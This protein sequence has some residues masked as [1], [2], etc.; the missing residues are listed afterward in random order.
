MSD[1]EETIAELNKHF[2]RNTIISG[3]DMKAMDIARV[4]TGS[5]SLDIETGGG[6]PYGRV[7]ELFGRE[8]TGKSFMA[9]KTA[10]QV[11]KAGKKVVWIDVEGSF[12]ATWAERIGLNVSQIHLARP[13]KGEVACDILDAVIRSGDCGLAVLDSTAALIPEADLDKSM[14][15]VEQI[16][17]RAK[18]VNRLTRKL[19]AALNQRVGEDAV[20]NNCL[21]I[22]I[23]QIREKIGVM[24][25]SPDT[26]PGGL[27]LKHAASIRVHF[28]KS[29]FKDPKDKDLVIGQTVTFV[30]EKNKTAPPNR[31]GEFVFYTDKELKGEIDTARE[32]FN[33]GLLTGL[34]E[35]VSGSSYMVGDNKIV[36]KENVVIALRETPKL[37]ETLQKKILDH[38]LKDKGADDE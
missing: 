5:L 30:T 1:L 26:T 8:S 34:I 29:W 14:D 2:G 13:D 31:K 27:G 18:L 37:V 10:V 24:W 33:Y 35:K 9:L 20:P 15:Q 4:S 21:V 7:V 12:D 38:F 28:R 3:N 32:V 23:N 22:F 17:T 16:G 25:G 36:G 6:L 11:Q 19:H